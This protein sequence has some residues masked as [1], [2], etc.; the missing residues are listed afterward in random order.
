MDWFKFQGGKWEGSAKDLYDTLFA[1]V[2]WDKQRYFPASAKSLADKLRRIL[3]ALRS[4]GIDVKRSE[5]KVR[6]EREICYMYT[7][8]KCYDAK[9]VAECCPVLPSEKVLSNKETATNYGNP[10]KCCPVAQSFFQ[11]N[12]KEEKEKDNNEEDNMLKKEIDKSWATGQHF[13]EMPQ[14]PVVSVLPS[15]KVLSNTGQHRATNHES[16]NT[17]PP[18]HESSMM[19]L[20]QYAKYIDETV[21]GIE[22]ERGKEFADDVRLACTKDTIKSVCNKLKRENP[23]R[24]YPKLLDQT[25]NRQQA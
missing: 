3:P 21:K 14:N 12:I 1:C 22:A 23:E 10:Q 2:S 8:F 9:T 25:C 18:A 11:N 17:D 5:K 6:N 19:T 16:N 15:E 13:C 4:H 20:N 24:L 7:I